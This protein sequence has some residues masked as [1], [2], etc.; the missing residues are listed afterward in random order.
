MRY[1]RRYSLVVH[2]S[3]DGVAPGHV[4]HRQLQRYTQSRLDQDT[5]QC[6]LDLL[7]RLLRHQFPR[8]PQFDEPFDPFAREWQPAESWISHLV[9][10]KDALDAAPI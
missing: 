9:S 10:I 4:V 1:I 3:G 7:V 8:R 5:F 2:V 6:A